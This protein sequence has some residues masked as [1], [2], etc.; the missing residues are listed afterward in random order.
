MIVTEVKKWLFNSL[1]K[2]MKGIRK[3]KKGPGLRDG[4]ISCF[5]H[6]IVRRLVS[7]EMKPRA[8]GLNDSD[9]E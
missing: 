8:D 6:D 5:C 7:I 9:F 3:V 4:K 1:E 2:E